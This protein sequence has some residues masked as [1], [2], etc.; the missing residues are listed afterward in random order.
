MAW[1]GALLFSVWALS[2]TAV[3][4]AAIEAASDPAIA[5][6][7][8]LW[9]TRDE[10]AAMQD[11]VTAGTKLMAANP[12][13]F[14]AEWRLARAYWWLALTQRDR[15]GRKALSVKAMEWA[16][17]ARA[18][19]PERVEGHY[20]M[21]V[22]VGE[23]A[24]TVGVMQALVDGVAGKVE[25]AAMRANEI[26]PDYA[27]GAPGIVLGRYYFM[28]PWPKR[29]L[30][31]SRGYLE[32]VVNRHPGKLIAHQFLAETYYALGHRDQAHGQLLLVLST[33]PAPETER[34]LPEPKPLAE[35]SLREW[36]GGH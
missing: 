23:Y 21:A 29:D 31:R 7:D 10:S 8:E 34:D 17:R 33:P 6:M 26:D 11:A 28:L 12:A 22:S 18:Q 24:A 15:V 20:Y 9:A 35:A 27:V 2:A 32:T 13:N 1:A 14:E 30:D 4:A 3:G 19:R 16:E 5:R 25:S 36:F